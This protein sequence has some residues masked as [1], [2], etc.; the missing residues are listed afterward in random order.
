MK[1]SE[2]AT[3]RPDHQN[4]HLCFYAWANPW[5]ISESLDLEE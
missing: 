1:N 5:Q 4:I 3:E 2:L